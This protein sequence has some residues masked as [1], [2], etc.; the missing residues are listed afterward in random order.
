M[1]SPTSACARSRCPTAAASAPLTRSLQVELPVYLLHSTLDQLCEVSASKHFQK[2]HANT[3]NLSK[4]VYPEQG[5][6]ELLQETALWKV[7]PT[8]RVL[9]TM[10]IRNIG[11]HV[12]NAL[13]PMNHVP[14]SPR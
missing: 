3:H 13:L 11:S 8:L 14:R 4:F 10:R 7:R 9:L 2:L 6:H 1:T 12:S 5:K